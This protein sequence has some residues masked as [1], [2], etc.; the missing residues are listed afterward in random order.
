M[1]NVLRSWDK[2]QDT[3]QYRTSQI[4][5]ITKSSPISSQDKIK[6][7]DEPNETI[8][9]DVLTEEKDEIAL[10]NTAQSPIRIAI[11]GK[12]NVG[13]S[14]LLNA[15]IGKERAITGDQAGITR[16]TI[17]VEHDNFIITDT[18][19]QHGITRQSHTKYDIIDC[20]AMDT[21]INTINKSHIIIIVLDIAS[22][23]KLNNIHEIP[24]NYRWDINKL[25]SSIT[26][27]FI[28]I[29]DTIEKNKQI[30]D[31]TSYN[32]SLDEINMQ[33]Y[34]CDEG[35]PVIVV[36]N[37]I[38]ILQS[39]QRQDITKNIQKG[40]IYMLQKRVPQFGGFLQVPI[41]AINNINI[42]TILKSCK[43]IYNKWEKR[44]S[45][46]ELNSWLYKFVQLT[47]PPRIKGKNIRLKYITQTNRKPPNF[48][49]KCSPNRDMVSLSYQKHITR[50]LR[51]EFGLYGIP[52]RIHLRNNCNPKRIIK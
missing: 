23:L 38:D 37:K 43:T 26:S 30:I 39:L 42:K 28:D 2:I 36:L 20:T 49:I 22:S 29:D 44:I 10:S 48:M 34:A 16:D 11:I 27:N 4:D 31:Y 6:S 41:S 13:K 15:L 12:P 19:G 47:P 45:T 24:K 1:E 18:A 7:T 5:N 3:F 14:T 32:L 40:F 51:N 35:K 9:A 8:S 33:R 46:H 25:P 21:T 17:E 52:I 50:A